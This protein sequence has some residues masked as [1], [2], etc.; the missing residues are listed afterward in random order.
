MPHPPPSR[1]FALCQVFDVYL[2]QGTRLRNEMCRELERGG[3]DKGVVSRISDDDELARQRFFWSAAGVMLFGH[4][5]LL[6]NPVQ[7]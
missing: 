7:R 1:T 2:A 4:P 6:Q 3:M 5:E